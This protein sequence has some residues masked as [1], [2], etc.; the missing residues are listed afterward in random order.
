M[1]EWPETGLAERSFLFSVE[2]MYA[3][4]VGT[5]FVWVAPLRVNMMW[6]WIKTRTALI[7]QLNCPLSHSVAAKRFKSRRSLK[8]ASFKP[9]EHKSREAMTDKYSI[10]D[11]VKED[12]VRRFLSVTHSESSWKD[13]TLIITSWPFFSPKFFSSSSNSYAAQGLVLLR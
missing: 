8:P 5:T 9:A 6:R 2:A 3:L 10:K 7:D 12:V 11:A 4:T 1:A 13:A